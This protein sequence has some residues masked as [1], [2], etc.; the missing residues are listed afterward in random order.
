MA[1]YLRDTLTGAVT[2]VLADDDAA[3]M[4]LLAQAN[5]P[6]RPAYEEVELTN[7]AVTPHAGSSGGGAGAAT[8]RKFPFA[9]DTA[10]LLT[11]AA[12]YTPT[13]GDVL[14]DA[15]VE[16][17]TAWNGTNPMGDLG[18]FA[19]LG[20]G[21]WAS[22]GPQPLN[23]NR[24]DA[25]DSLSGLLI[26]NQLSSLRDL[27]AVAMGTTDAGDALYAVAGVAVNFA[28]AP[29]YGTRLVPSKLVGGVPLKFCVSQ[30]GTKTGA[31]PASTV[32]AATLYLVTATPV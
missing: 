18:A 3:Y 30:D 1:R 6:N 4:T 29:P 24:V 31:N 27:M 23:M 19:A 28:T 20:A 15:W 16:I 25:V 2:T 14:L 9:H 13:D 8:I 10:G 11:G 12:L 32:G 26:G 22:Y 21:I 5:K 17:E 7:P